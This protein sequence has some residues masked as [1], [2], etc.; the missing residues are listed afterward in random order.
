MKSCAFSKIVQLTAVALPLIF[1]SFSTSCLAADT[2]LVVVITKNE[3]CPCGSHAGGFD[4]LYQGKQITINFQHSPSS[5]NPVQHPVTVHQQDRLVKE[6]D[7]L[8]CSLP[9]ETC[10][11]AG[12]QVTVTGKW[13]DKNAFVAHRVIIP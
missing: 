9:G 1:T 13:E 10:P 2:S 12:K 6:W 7:A 8:I 3:P 4:A 5:A 11:I